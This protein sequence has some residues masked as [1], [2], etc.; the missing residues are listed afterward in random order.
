MTAMPRLI[1]IKIVMW[2]LLRVGLHLQLFNRVT[3]YELF[4]GLRLFQTLEYITFAPA[5]FEALSIIGTHG[6]WVPDLSAPEDPNS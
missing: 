3:K 4:K 2:K 1:S 5:D 6:F